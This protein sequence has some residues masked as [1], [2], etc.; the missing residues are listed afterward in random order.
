MVIVSWNVREELLACIESVLAAANVE[1]RV[2]VVDNASTD[3]SADAV[4]ERFPSVTLVRNRANRGFA[5]AANQGMAAGDA[6][7]V[8]LLNPDTLV[9][10]DGISRLVTKLDVLPEHAMI[11]PRLVD[12][13]GR[14]QQSVYLFPSVAIA[15]LVGL[16][17]H[18]LLP[19]SQK[20]RLL[21]P[22]FWES[23]ER[24]V[25]WAVGA[26]MLVRRS[27]IDRV[28]PLDESFFV[29]VEDMEWCDRLRRAGMRIRFSP[30][31]T[32]I[33]HR[34]RSG[35][36]RFGASR[37]REYLTATSRFLRRGHSRLWV[38]SFDGISTVSA[39]AHAVPSQVAA[40]VRPTPRRL[41]AAAYWRDQADG[42]LQPALA[43]L[44]PARE[45]HRSRRRCWLVI[46]ASYPPHH[47]GGYE[48]MCRDH[49]ASMPAHGVDAVVLTSTLGLGSRA[50]REE[51]GQGGE[52]ISRSLTFRDEEFRSRRFGRVELCR[53]E[54]RQ[55]QILDEL[56]DRSAPEAAILWMMGGLSASL[57][58]SLGRRGL[59]IVVM[60]HEQWPARR[61]GG[62]PWIDFWT[63]PAYHRIRR[64]LKPVARPVVG[65]LVAP[66]DPAPALAAAT[67]VYCSQSLRGDVE[68]ALPAW[69]G[70]GTV[71]HDGI[72]L[73]RMGRPRDDTEPI[74]DPLRLLYAGRVERRKGV[75]VA[76]AVLGA[77]RDAGIRAR[78]RI[79]GWREPEYERDLRAQ[80]ERLGVLE[81]VDWTDHLP[82]EAMPD[83]YRG[84]DVLLFP[85]IWREPFGLSPLEAMATG[86]LVV[87][88]GSGGSGE[89]LRDG[90]NALLARVNDERATGQAVLR[91]AAESRLVAALRRGGRRTVDRLRIEATAEAYNR[92]VERAIAASR[93]GG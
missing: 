25:P 24:D 34:N 83:V 86:C 19:R 84:A 8:F 89:Y 88:T 68:A 74:A 63:R 41:D 12:T 92:A 90:E 59:P 82:H 48:L 20:N 45:A 80:A 35:S 2:I 64:L 10:A 69:R 39:C 16:G 73:N 22:G 4:A 71:V 1:A 44:R 6:S 18:H 78:L 26:A 54:R 32:V 17:G 57:I 23:T 76:I 81:R 46:G 85:S 66:V 30:E 77:L 28:G 9:P 51:R 3:G 60:V 33:H 43:R 75:H 79:V 65:R 62:D 50:P 52:L 31:V 87:A 58:A 13:E 55:R 49:V 40:S 53:M 11:V 5:A 70:R 7:W 38:G 61:F 91:L 93:G 42:R 72:D 37:T 27:A 56:L 14:S 67:P 36:Q 47:R 21:I 15:L 29:Y